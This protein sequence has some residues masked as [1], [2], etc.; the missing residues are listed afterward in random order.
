MQAQAENK[1]AE[2]DEEFSDDDAEV[3]LQQL[4]KI[5]LRLAKALCAAMLQ[6]RGAFQSQTDVARQ[7]NA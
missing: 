4:L 7:Y 2:S 6:T 5:L 1:D 3:L